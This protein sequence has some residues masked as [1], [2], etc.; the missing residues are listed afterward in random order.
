M[1]ERGSPTKS[2]V[3]S[4]KITMTSSESQFSLGDLIISDQVNYIHPPL[5]VK[6]M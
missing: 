5:I 1:V 4:F 6:F 2:M 3:L